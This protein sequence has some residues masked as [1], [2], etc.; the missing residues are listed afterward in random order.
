MRSKN[1][2]YD[3]EWEATFH[4]ISDGMAILDPEGRVVRVNIA[5]ARM[6]NKTSCDLV[7]EPLLDIFPSS[8]DIHAECPWQKVVQTRQAACVEIL[9][10]SFG[11]H[12]EV[13]AYPVFGKTKSVRAVAVLIKDV[14]QR[15]WLEQMKNDFVNT[16]SHELRTPLTTIRE[17]VSQFLDGVLGHISTDQKN[18]LSIAIED[19][20]RLT[21]I[22]N[23]LLD[24]SKIEARKIDLRRD[25]VDFAALVNQLLF[26][27]GP[28]FKDK[29]LKLSTDFS[30]EKI[31][32]Y[33]DK[34]RIIQVFTNL[35]SNAFKFTEKGG[36]RIR[37]ED[38]GA[39]GVLCSV[40]DTGCGIAEEDIPKVFSKFEQFGRVDGPGAKGTGLGLSIAR[41]IIELHAGK[42]WVESQRDKGTTFFFTLPCYSTAEMIQDT[43][44]RKLALA[45]REHKAVSVF[46]FRFDE[47]SDAE[48]LA[49]LHG[50][51]S[52]QAKSGESVIMG[53]GNEIV[54][55]DE[56]GSDYADTVLARLRLS[57]KEAL[58]DFGGALWNADFSYAVATFPD[59]AK[60]TQDLLDQC[61]QAQVHEVEERLGKRIILADDDSSV[62]KFLKDILESFGY[63][64]I[65]ECA[66]GEETLQAARQTHPDLVILDM[67]MPRLNGYEVI[68]HLKEDMATHDIPI[69]IL[70]GY[71]VELDQISEYV[72]RKAIP[73]MGKPVQTEE[74]HKIISHL[75]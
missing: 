23:G 41:G 30:A 18:F 20:D 66:D 5:F 47:R 8:C 17:V 73:V 53:D 39:E 59:D 22:I 11:K 72:K 2:G 21:R 63:R 55:I 32:A 27:F 56:V 16:V 40:A 67:K 49:R 1:S 68:G 50:R 74:L 33:A 44:E 60:N 46:V 12:L 38:K 61:R 51:L 31:E 36:V 64:H 29:G 10:S 58:L 15:K 70:S 7:G 34:D 62:R 6:F 3:G 43:V 65:T 52:S 42:V 4:A 54:V 25:V 26:T 9:V 37:I 13:S 14:T 75:L 48:L 35:L 28:R 71:R 19:I 57:V 69:I 24:I 45:R